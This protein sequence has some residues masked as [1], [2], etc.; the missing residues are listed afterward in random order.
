MNDNIIII[1]DDAGVRFFLE[2]ALKGEGYTPLSFESYEDA[3]SKINHEVSLVIMDIKLPGIDGLSAIDE[4]KKKTDIPIVIVTAYGTKKNAM[5]AIQ[6]GAADFF[7][8]PIALDELKIVVK[9]TL[10]KSKLKKEVELS[11]EEGLK[12]VVF[13]GVVGKSEAMKD[14]FKSVEKF[15]GKDITVLIT[16]ETGVGKEEIAKLIHK[17]SKRKG[18]L[19]TVNCAS[20]PD[21][22]LESELFGYEKGAFTG[23]TQQKL[24]KFELAEG[25]TIVLDEIGEMSPYLQ[26][27]LLRV[28][29]TKEIDKLGDVKKRKINARIIATTNRDI[30]Q[31]IKDG[32]F[33]EDLYFR[34]AQMFITVPPLRTRKDDIP[35][36][37][38]HYLLAF[39]KD[40]NG[41]KHIDKDVLDMLVKYDWPGNV[42]E[43]INSLKRA[44]IMCDGD[45]IKLDDLPLHLKSKQRLNANTYSDTL[46]DDAIS[47][48]EKQMIIDALKK[49]KGSQAKAAK[50]LGISERSMWYRVKKYGVVD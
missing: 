9:R 16:G 17:L 48:M 33:R 49:T 1:E 12:D 28:I 29:E 43:L 26:A 15:A 50:L 35:I 36:L 21:N 41:L 25:G 7:I 39:S 37:I 8:K 20:I 44:A 42:R 14:I 30:V 2:E 5:E 31:E 27:K 32:R 11:K 18:K 3:V 6:R 40:S 19:I 45:Q 22:L 4:I 47:A 23:A 10:G 24:G 34:L 38:E 46:L 13:Y